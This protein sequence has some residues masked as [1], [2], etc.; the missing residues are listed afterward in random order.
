VTGI[1]R[2]RLQITFYDAV[3]NDGAL[4]VIPGATSVF[5]DDLTLTSGGLL[6]AKL[7]GYGAGSDYPQIEVGGEAELAGLLEVSL[8][9][10]F[11]PG[12]GDA[13]DLIVADRG[14]TGVFDTTD[15]PVLPTAL[16]WELEYS[17]LGLI[18]MSQ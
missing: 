15:L 16:S 17:A 13:F 18:A 3:I 4:I 2:V 5:V 14:V 7:E 10:A 8:D 1:N 11:S 12:E 6:A 9:S